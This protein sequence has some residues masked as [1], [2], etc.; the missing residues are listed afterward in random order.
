MQGKPG[1]RTQV[2]LAMAKMLMP[3]LALIWWATIPVVLSE[4]QSILLD[5]LVLDP[6]TRI[7]ALYTPDQLTKNFLISPKDFR[8]LLSIPGHLDESDGSSEFTVDLGTDQS[9]MTVYA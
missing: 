8:F 5:G 4:E 6:G 3:I 1:K 7:D 2:C 9:I